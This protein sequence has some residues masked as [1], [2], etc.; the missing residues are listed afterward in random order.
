MITSYLK[1]EVEP[2]LSVSRIAGLV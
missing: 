2:S 1:T